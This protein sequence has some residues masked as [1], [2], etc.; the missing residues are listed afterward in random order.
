MSSLHEPRGNLP[1]LNAV[2]LSQIAPENRRETRGSNSTESDMSHYLHFEDNDCFF[3]PGELGQKP[4]TQGD[5]QSP[6]LSVMEQPR[7]PE[8]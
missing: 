7:A 3:P 8:K 2:P 6:R 4:P 5:R 1:A